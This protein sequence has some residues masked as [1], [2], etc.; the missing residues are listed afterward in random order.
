WLAG[1]QS[2][3]NGQFVP[4]GCRGFYQRGEIRTR[5]DQQPIEAYATVAAYLDAARVTEN[6]EWRRQARTAFGWFL[7][8]NDLRIPLFDAATGACYDG[9][10]PNGANLNQGAESTLAFLLASLELRLA[11]A[12]SLAEEAAQE[13]AR[14]LAVKAAELHT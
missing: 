6:A 10:Q 1:V 4:I 12:E 13:A 3:E 14:L 7:G 9:L 8:D 5:F 2:G 11:D